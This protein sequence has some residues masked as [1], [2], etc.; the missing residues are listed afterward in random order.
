MH[1]S[2]SFRRRASALAAVA[3]VLAAGALAL[4]VGA[5]AAY[6]DNTLCYGHIQRGVKDD[7]GLLDHPVA[8]KFACSNPITSYQIITDRR[9][10][11]FDTEVFPTDIKGEIV[12][13][14]AFSCNGET[15]GFGVNCVGVYSGAWGVIPGQFN[16]SDS[17]ICAEPRVDPLLVVTYATYSKNADGSPKLDSQKRPVVTENAAGPFDLGRP[18]G[19]PRTKRSG[20]LHIPRPSGRDTPA[21]G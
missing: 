12:A 19:C 16:L 2:P 13:T 21:A 10:D 14:D 4:P 8:Y 15:P 7:L 3:A 5:G 11:A 18:H 1:K 20:T 6:T 9:I 17:S